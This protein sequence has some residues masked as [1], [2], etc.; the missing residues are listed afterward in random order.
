ML[1]PDIRPEPASYRVYTWTKERIV[2]GTLAAGTMISEGEISEALD[3]SRTPVREAFLRLAAEGILDLFPKRGAL[4]A[5]VTVADMRNV[6]EARLLIEPW[7]AGVAAGLANR[8]ELVTR[9]TQLV[10]EMSAAQLP[11]EA[12]QYRE[13]DR[14]FHKAIVAATDNTLIEAF[15]QSLRDRQL[16]M[17]F[18]ALGHA[19]GRVEHSHSEHRAI[20]RAIAAGD[21]DEAAE[22]VRSHVSKNRAAL[23]LKLRVS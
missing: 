13:T 4:V 14:L 1:M 15:Y 18:A 6:M 22:L 9:L 2:D 7:A 19:E 11:E 8:Q 3:V 5:P 16:R 23:E 21:P 17:G 12:L 20:A 10:S